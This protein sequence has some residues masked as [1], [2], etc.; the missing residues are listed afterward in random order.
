M[1]ARAPILSEPPVREQRQFG[2]YTLRYRVAQGGMA[3]VYLAQL[4]M[5]EG[6]SKWVAIKTIQPR[7]ASDERF[8]T[9]FLDEARL[10]SRID[11]PNVCTVLDFGQ[12]AGTYYIAMEYLHGESLAAVLRR[13]RHRS[14]PLSLPLGARIL[15][16]IARGLHA[17]HELRT[18][19]G[20]N[21]GVVHRDVSPQNIFVLYEGLSKVVDFGI[22]R[23]EERSAEKTSTNEIKGKL[24]YMSPEQLMQDPIDRRSD[25]FSLGAVLWEATTGERL[26]KREKDVETILSVIK[27][28]I[29]RPS[30]KV[31][32]FPPRLEEIVMR[33]LQRKPADRYETAALLARDLE[34]FIVASGVSAG[35]G[36]VSDMMTALF[37]DHI[38]ARDELLRA[39]V[40]EDA[41]G[42][43]MDVELESH[44]K[45]LRGPKVPND[46][47]TTVSRPGR[48][49]ERSR[50]R[51][52]DL[53]P[54]ISTEAAEAPTAVARLRRSRRFVMPLVTLAAL[55]VVAVAAWSLGR[56][57]PAEIAPRPSASAHEP[58]PAP[59]EVARA[60]P[61]AP[62]ARPTAVLVEPALRTTAAADVSLPSTAV[63]SPHVTPRSARTTA[64][65]SHPPALVLHDASAPARPSGP[66]PMIDFEVPR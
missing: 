23:W 46:V 32:D 66:T 43:V 37:A 19:E 5:E 22:A 25:V 20:T 50:R 36:D 10:V 7:I 14:T 44:S 41:S 47:P 17:A 15:A 30:E 6:F 9:M 21:A 54:P 56:S 2:R 24:Q 52:Q 26:F 1:N 34:N 38:E 57:R 61:E 16:D 8:V 49:S 31:A 58:A 18:A 35:H 63:V 53:G 55:G 65:L 11:H 39:K 40:D 59:H 60:T 62:H 13:L 28:P 33:A 51:A 48:R 45:S 4:R 12:D 27:E 64:G 29:P 42:A 3:C